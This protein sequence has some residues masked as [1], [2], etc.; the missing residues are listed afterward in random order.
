M[1][2][3][4]HTFRNFYHCPKCDE[5]WEDEWDST[6]DDECPNCGCICTPERSEDI[7]D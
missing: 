3:F 1:K 7:E 5:E 2:M 6:C 4:E